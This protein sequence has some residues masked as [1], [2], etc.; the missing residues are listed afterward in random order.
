MKTHLS[1]FLVFLTVLSCSSGDREQDH[2][3]NNDST[4]EIEQPNSGLRYL[5]LGDSYTIG[6]GVDS[7]QSYPVQIWDSLVEMGYSLEQPEIIAV[8]GWTTTNLKAGIE[9]AS[10]VGPYDL[11]SLLIGVNN[12][13]Q[14]MDIRIYRREFEELLN[15]SIAFAGN[16]TGRV[17]VF[18]IPDYGVT[19]FASG[20]DKERIAGEID[21]Y[22]A[23]NREISLNKGVTWIDVTGISRMAEDDLSLIAGDGLHP[24]GRMYTAWVRLSIPE[25]LKML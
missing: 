6:E 1:G 20:A 8:T 11:V 17:I 16:D 4:E 2:S 21:Q 18:S 15:L 3:T 5:A 24:S 19:P 25:I 12:Q 10:P 22:N 13:Y 14:G 7:S 23:I 9:A